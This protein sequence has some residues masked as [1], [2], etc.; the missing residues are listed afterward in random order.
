MTLATRCP[1]CGTVFRVVQDQLRVSQ[2]WVR[3]GRCSEAFNALEAMVELPLPQPPAGAEAPPS[4][5]LPTPVG[6]TDSTRAAAIDA[7][8]SHEP[9]LALPLPSE[10][11]VAPS[12]G[13]RSEPAALDRTTNET[14]LVEIPPGLEVVTS[15]GAMR[16][17]DTLTATAAEAEAEA[18]RTEPSFEV[19]VAP[20]QA[21]RDVGLAAGDVLPA[22]MGLPLARSTG[23]LASPQD[24]TAV[25]PSASPASPSPPSPASAATL[26]SASPAS[27]APDKAPSFLIQAERA[28]RWRH[29]AVRAVLSI[30]VL[31][32]A[33]GLAA[34]LAYTF[35]DR[36]AATAPSLRPALL[37]ACAVAGCRVGEYRQIDALSVESSGLVRVEG[38]PV[39]RLSVTLRNRAAVEV[40]AP[41]LELAL[42]DAQGRL[43]ARRVLRMSDLDL[44]LR[45]LKPG[46]ELPIQAP[47][48][49]GDRQVSGYT[50]EIFYP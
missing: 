11:Q 2:G 23:T 22:P 7:V 32:A 4:V 37:Q 15:D 18:A 40:A 21:L 17:G 47:L 6:P 10:R 24:E 27:A 44:P 25:G 16:T 46:S 3:C 28:E 50:V 36:I 30:G 31:L 20:G 49:I 29:P 5:M 13:D 39:V 48:D 14:T 8:V 45:S 42:T 9:G 35:R 38:S 43:M 19:D 1:A 12:A 33:L 41:A 34:Q 26:P